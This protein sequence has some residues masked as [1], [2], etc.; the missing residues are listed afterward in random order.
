MTDFRTVSDDSPLREAIELVL[1]GAQQ[2]FPVVGSTDD[3]IVSVLN[4]WPT[5]LGPQHA[6]ALGVRPRHYDE[7]FQ[8]RGYE[9]DARSVFLRL[10]TAFSP[11]LPVFHDGR[12]V[13][14]LTLENVSEYVKIRGALKPTR[15]FFA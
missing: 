14:L 3:K 4:P 5:R 8:N 9:R 13:G 11:V 1:M 12:L 2:D 7:R 10:Q 15:R 6:R